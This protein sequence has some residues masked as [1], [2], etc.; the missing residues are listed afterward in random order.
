L[1]SKVNA[2][3]LPPVTVA[4]GNVWECFPFV[5]GGLWGPVVGADVYLGQQGTTGIALPV[6]LIDD[7][8]ALSPTNDCITVT[9]NSLLTTAGA[10]GANGI[11]GIGNTIV[12]C[13]VDCDSTPPLYHTTAAT[14]PGSSV[15]YYGCPSAA[16]SPTACG[17]TTILDNSQVQNPVAAL[18]SP[19]NNG[20]VLKMPAI[21][22]NQPGAATAAGELILGVDPSHLP[23]NATQVFLGTHPNTNPDSYLSITTQYNNHVFV[24]SYLDTGTN[25]LFFYDATLANSACSSQQASSYWYCPSTTLSNLQAILSD[26]DNPTLH[27]VSVSFQIANFAILSA[28]SNTAFSDSGGAVNGQDAF[29]NPIPDTKTFAWGLPFFYGKQ[30]ALSIW[31]QSGSP[32]G[33]WVAWAPL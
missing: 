8:H 1:A 14:P 4:S 25:G 17:L 22:A 5:I 32:T 27:Q 15:L 13:G 31:Q 7:Q 9:N 16:T 21:P 26:G 18:A 11:L 23:G 29:G 3:S 2:L 30:V 6:Q 20:V 12:D 24:N 33:P 10:V 19:Y 28:T